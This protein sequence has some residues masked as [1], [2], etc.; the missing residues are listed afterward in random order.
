V[1]YIE[2]ELPKGYRILFKTVSDAI[3]AIERQD[4]GE[5]KRILIQG[6]LDAEDA[7]MGEV[8]AAETGHAKK[9]RR[10]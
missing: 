4:F 1:E 5:T 7:F 9:R 8:E 2:Y 3:D 6:E 10:C